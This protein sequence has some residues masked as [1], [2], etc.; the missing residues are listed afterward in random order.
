MN[1]DLSPQRRR[2]AQ[3]LLRKDQKPVAK[4]SD[5]AGLANGGL[6]VVV[7]VAVEEETRLGSR[8]VVAEG[9]EAQ[10]D[11]VVAVM[12]EARRVVRHEKVH[13]GKAGHELFHL[14][15]LEQVVAPGL[16]FP[17]AAEAAEGESVELKRRHVQVTDG[18]AKW[19]ARIMVAFDREN[20]ATAAPLR[21]FQNDG[22]GQVAQ[23]D[24]QVRRLVGNPAS[25]EFVIGNDQEVHRGAIVVQSG[26]RG[27]GI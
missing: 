23:G 5:D 18:C 2:D 4:S 27:N 19:R 6:D 26:E 14:V 15:L 1:A 8:D 16:V 21:G 7:L 20:V 10:V 3:R 9:D 12:H 22:V 17:G 25:Y 11:L 24:E 13:G